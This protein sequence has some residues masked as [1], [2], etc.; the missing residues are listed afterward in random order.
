MTRRI[1]SLCLLIAAV[2]AAAAAI[3]FAVDKRAFS[4]GLPP[5]A[6]FSATLLPEPEG[7][8]SWSTLAEVGQTIENDKEVP[9]FSRKVLRLD[10]KKVTIYGFIMPLE[11]GT[12]QR[13]FLLSAVP[14]GCP[15]CMPVGPE[16]VVEIFS[17]EP[18]EYDVQPIAMVGR[19]A[20][21][22]DDPN[23]LLYKL[24]EA[25]PVDISTTGK[26]QPTHVHSG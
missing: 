24:T 4:P 26:P 20:V 12:K 5:A 3:R 8:V 15:F 11:T 10:N 6:R 25:A 21:L 18:V 16:G 2:A 14:P 9:E 17:K 7:A 1:I 19:F 22:R 13:H 23:V